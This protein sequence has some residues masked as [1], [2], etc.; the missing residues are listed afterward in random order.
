MHPWKERFPVEFFRGVPETP[1]IYRFLSNEGKILYVGK[2][3]NLRARLRSYRYL[4]PERASRK[5]VRLVANTRSIE[6]ELESSER[7]ALLHENRLLRK[8]RPMYNRQNTKPEA[9]IFLRISSQASAGS[10]KIWRFDISAD[11]VSADERSGNVGSK[12]H[13]IGCFKGRRALREALAAYLRIGMLAE[14]KDLSFWQLPQRWMK[15]EVFG[16]QEIEVPTETSRWVLRYWNGLGTR[17]LSL[18][19][20]RLLLREDL[21]SYVRARI[22]AD[23]NLLKTFAEGPLRQLRRIRKIGAAR[24]TTSYVPKDMIDDFKVELAFD[25]PALPPAGG[26]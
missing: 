16:P 9:Y 7:D 12:L 19:A 22:Q 10:S 15:E 14:R 24:L 8:L 25:G 1:G 6:W 5:L 20:E 26:S 4:S 13:I 2:A 18:W 11:D 17:L 21:D 23:L 3:K